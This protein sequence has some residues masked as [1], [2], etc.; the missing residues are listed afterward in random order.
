MPVLDWEPSLWPENLLEEAEHVQHAPL[1]WWAIHVRPR[2]E[3]M[4]ARKLR[5]RRVGFYLPVHEK[6]QKYQRRI[7]TSRVPLFPGY[8][9]AYADGSGSE[10][11]EAKEVVNLIPVVEQNTLCR[12]LRDI[13]RLVDSGAPITAEERLEVGMPARIVRGP[14]AGMSGE[15]LRNNRGLKFVLKVQFIQR[16]ASIEIDGA[17]VEAV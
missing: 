9:F 3:K 8:L 12:Q 1:R 11:A 2:A 14:L 4:L 15:V 5:V 6:R 7:V 16:A 13:R 17:M 10:L